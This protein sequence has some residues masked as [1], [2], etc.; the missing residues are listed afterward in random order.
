M[1]QLSTKGNIYMHSYCYDRVLK[2]YIITIRAAAFVHARNTFDPILPQSNTLPLPGMPGCP[3]R[4]TDAKVG[5]AWNWCTHESLTWR[6]QSINATCLNK[7]KTPGTSSHSNCFTQVCFR[8][9]CLHQMYS[10]HLAMPLTSQG[11]NG[12]LALLLGFVLAA[13]IQTGIDIQRTQ[14]TLQKFLQRVSDVL[15]STLPNP[16]KA[17]RSIL[18]VLHV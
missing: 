13:S 18:A 1:L 3:A 17:E 4:C 16:R 2:I 10:V 6:Q 14:R 7:P 8:H 5:I 9:R 12:N 11:W 15:S